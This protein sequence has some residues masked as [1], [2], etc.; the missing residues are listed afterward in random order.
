V[1][2]GLVPR[3][4]GLWAILLL[5]LLLRVAVACWPVIHHADELWQYLEPARRLAGRPWVETWEARAGARSWLLPMLFVAPM[6]IG[7]AIAPA[8]LLDIILPR[9][10]CVALSLG[11]VIGAARLGYRISRVHGLIAAFAACIWY[12][13]VYFG[14]RTMSEPIATAAFLAA[15]GLLLT[16]RDA[17]R[18]IIGGV[19]LGLCCVVRFQYGPAA[20]VL[21]I[22]AARLDRRSWM[23]LA[24]GGAIALAA[25]AAADLVAGATPFLWVVRNVT[26][27]IVDN[28]SAA[29]GVSPPWWYLKAIVGLWGWATI[30]IMAAALI[31]ARRYPSLFVA[32][33][34][35]LAVHSL[36]PHKEYRFILL[37]T[38][39][40][41][42]L[43]AIG[44]VDLVRRR[45][46]GPRSVMVLGATWLLLSAACGALGSS[47]HGWG[48][49]GRLIAAWRIAGRVPEACGVGVFR[50]NHALVASHALFGRDAPIY[51]IDGPG[52][53]DAERSRA[54]NLIITPWDRRTGFTDYR[55]LGC[56]DRRVRDFCVFERPGTCLPTEAAIPFEI[57]R[58]LHRK[59]I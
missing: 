35:N 48:N 29:F 1:T 40:L 2:T 4:R 43:G 58:V 5:A 10:L 38:S 17:R 24:I 6:E 34:V 3:D 28:R 39:L 20:L 14:P 21:A 18:T 36:V 30:P 57:N 25:S 52:A 32:A 51:Q 8:T 54:F 55:L 33:L 16:E 23:Q 15:A 11:A 19:L 47:A 46:A 31:G 7:R 45:F 42:A 59:E 9:L 27:N 50:P 12:E 44:S 22:A 13:L 56:G 37:T 26:L 53:I 49:N 41:V